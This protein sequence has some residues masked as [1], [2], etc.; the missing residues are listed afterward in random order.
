[1]YETYSKRMPERWRTVGF[2]WRLS[3]DG[4]LQLFDRLGWPVRVVKKPRT[5]TYNSQPSFEAKLEVSSG[6]IQ[7]ELDF[8]YS[9]GTT[10]RDAGTLYSIRVRWKAK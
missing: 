3:Y 10:T 8:N 1:M 2:D 9:K 7:I 4:W 5:G 6:N